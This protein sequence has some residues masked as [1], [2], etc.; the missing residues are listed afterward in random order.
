ML[1]QCLKESKDALLP[2]GCLVIAF[3]PLLNL[4]IQAP[5]RGAFFVTLMFR[6]GTKKGETTRWLIRCIFET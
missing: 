6:Y 1:V 5:H 2:I 4:F 3:P